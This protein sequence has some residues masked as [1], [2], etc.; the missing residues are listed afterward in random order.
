[1][2]E[3]NQDFYA[4]RSN[5]L[6]ETLTEAKGCTNCGKK[7]VNTK[8]CTGCKFAKYCNVDCQ[9]A[10][11]KK[12]KPVCKATR[13]AKET[14]SVF[15]RLLKSWDLMNDEELV[16]EMEN[17]SK[18]FIEE[19]VRVG[20]RSRFP[21]PN[22]IN[23]GLT[24]VCVE[25][26]DNIVR[27]T[28]TARFGTEE[29]MIND[30]HAV[31]FKTIDQ[32]KEA[33]AQLY[34]PDHGFSMFGAPPGEIADDKKEL[35]AK[36]IVEFVDQLKERDLRVRTITCGRGLPWLKD[37]KELYDRGIMCMEG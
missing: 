31:L 20:H 27:L 35:A 5:E 9:K 25:D 23:M 33:I 32:G 24:V 26:D 37:N 30:V 36:Y 19:V 15:C 11:W 16:K 18:L 1:M 3:F 13:S 7:D 17:Y 6:L 12:H 2:P 14:P 28:A 21:E 4:A 29:K 8:R 34:P 10:D 22:S